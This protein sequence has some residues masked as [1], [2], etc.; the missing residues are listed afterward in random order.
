MI[1]SHQLLNPLIMAILSDSFHW[2]V[3]MKKESLKVLVPQSCLTL[4][5][6]M[7]Y[8][9]QAPLSMGFSRQ[10]YWSGLPFPSPEDLPNP[11][12]E[13]GSPALQAD[14]LLSK[15]WVGCKHVLNVKLINTSRLVLSAMDIWPTVGR[16]A[17]G[18]VSSIPGSGRSPG[19]GNGNPLQYSCLENPKRH[20]AGYSAWCC[21]QPDMTEWQH[22]HTN[23][24]VREDSLWNL[25]FRHDR[26]T[27]IQVLNL[28]RA[29][30]KITSS[31]TN[32]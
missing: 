32:F 8:S 13:P 28:L 16:L 10:E 4:C 7:D 30:K 19:E 5:D 9:H 27:E 2:W 31:R 24:S 26:R 21:K 12:V 17:A 1:F 20:L 6:T 11:G 18:D 29:Y 15:P 25:I 23:Q 22:A 3:N 14:S